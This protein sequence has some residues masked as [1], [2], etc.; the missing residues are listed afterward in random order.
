MTRRTTSPR[1]EAGRA[2]LRAQIIGLI[3]GAVLVLG[4]SAMAIWL[5]LPIAAALTL[6]VL[7]RICWLE[8]NIRSD[9]M[10]AHDL[11]ASYRQTQRL[12][13]LWWRALLG[14]AP[15]P[16]RCPRQLASEMRLQAHALH[17]FVAGAASGILARVVDVPTAAVV[18]AG[19]A[20]A[21]ALWRVERLANAEAA[22]A[23]QS[24]L[25]DE[26]LEGL[27][28]IARFMMNR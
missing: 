14:A 15:A 26:M 19:G 25:S 23:R 10:G 28:P 1:P 22:M 11:P 5:P 6:A 12:Q 13:A 17:A 21:G 2:E 4:G 18:L 7:M 9:L 8:D 16:V 3:C 27:G 24:V 20:L